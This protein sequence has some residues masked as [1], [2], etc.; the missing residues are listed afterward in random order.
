MK[1]VHI[2]I[3]RYKGSDKE[4]EIIFNSEQDMKE[5]LHIICNNKNKEIVEFY[6]MELVD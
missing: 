3:W 5:Y 2:V 1:M 4:R 6:S